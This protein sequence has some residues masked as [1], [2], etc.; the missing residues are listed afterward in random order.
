MVA[1]HRTLISRP[2][3]VGPRP[4][5]IKEPCVCTLAIGRNSECNVGWERAEPI[6]RRERL[7]AQK[8]GGEL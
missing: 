8:K 6:V 5:Q 4:E 1:G 2:H 3:S 7:G